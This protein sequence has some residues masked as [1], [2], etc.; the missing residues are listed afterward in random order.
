MK[1]S[2]AIFDIQAREGIVARASMHRDNPGDI[3]MSARNYPITMPTQCAVMS[4]VNYCLTML[5]EAAEEDPSIKGRY[6]FIVP[7]NVAI[8][9]FEAQKCVNNGSD[10]MSSLFKR[11]MDTP[12]YNMEFTDEDG[13]TQLVNVWQIAIAGLANELQVMMDKTS[14]WSLNFV[15]SRTLYRYEIKRADGG[16]ITDILSVGDTVN[17]NSGVDVEKGLVCTEFNFLTGQFTVTRR[18]VRDR[19]QNITPHFYVPRLIQAINE[20]DGSQINVTANEIVANENLEP[21]RQSGV[22]VVNAAF[23]RTKTAEMLPRIKSIKSATVTTV[24]AESRQF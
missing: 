21:M 22:N 19:N 8:R 4:M 7:E 5:R 11:W 23:L 20:E 18:D 16:D 10:I 14:G 17:F 3:T 9:F 6:T 12:Q 13:E 15:N 2:K 24:D 1:T